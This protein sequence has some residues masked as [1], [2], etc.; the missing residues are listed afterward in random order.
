MFKALKETLSTEL[1][2]SMGV[3]SCHIEN[4]NEEVEIIKTE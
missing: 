2:K 1:K 3:M 4:I